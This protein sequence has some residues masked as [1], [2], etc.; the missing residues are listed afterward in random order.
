MEMKLKDSEFWILSEKDNERIIFDNKG[1]AISKLR[2]RMKAG[3]GPDRL[4]LVTFDVSSLDK[5]QMQGVSWKEIA[6]GFAAG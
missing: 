6:A 5:V 3:V 4:E 2:D 1:E